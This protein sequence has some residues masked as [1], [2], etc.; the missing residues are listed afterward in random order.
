M[1][2][3]RRGKDQRSAGAVAHGAR[4]WRP[5][6]DHRLQGAA[7]VA[8]LGTLCP[9]QQARVRIRRFIRTRN[10]PNTSI[11][12]APSCKGVPPGRS[13]I[14]RAAVEDF[15]VAV[16][17]RLANAAAANSGRYCPNQPTRI[18]NLLSAGVLPFTQRTFAMKSVPPEDQ[19][20]ELQM[21]LM[22]VEPPKYAVT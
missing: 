12:A 5:G 6:R 15:Y 2:R 4:Q 7:P 19:L 20:T 18:L 9:H 10:A 14:F 11:S 1:A 21:T 8:N 3:R 16:G 13:P 22:A 17:Q